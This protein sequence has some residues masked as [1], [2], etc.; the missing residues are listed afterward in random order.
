MSNG[1]ARISALQYA[2][3]LDNAKKSRAFIAEINGKNIK[4]MDD[5]LSAVWKAFRFPQTGHV[6]YYAYLDW[7]RD[8]DWLAADSFIFT[9]R[10]I[11]S[12][13]TQSP[14][15]KELVIG[16]IENTVIPWW[17]SKIEQFQV[18]GKAKPFNVYFIK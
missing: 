12:F 14:K 15:E 5:Y 9:I 18:G 4:N 13:M 7:I 6:N 11:D 16:S 3:I 10:N 17:E 8:L 1:I 2:T